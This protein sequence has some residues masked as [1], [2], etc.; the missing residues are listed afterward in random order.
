MSGPEGVI[1]TTE[2]E[3]SQHIEE[4]VATATSILL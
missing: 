3:D 1:E 2:L 4:N